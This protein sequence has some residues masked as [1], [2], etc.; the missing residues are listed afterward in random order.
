MRRASKGFSSSE[1]T[2]TLVT[3]GSSHN[4]QH[5][6]SRITSIRVVDG[7]SNS[8]RQCGQNRAC[9]DPL[10]LRVLPSVPQPSELEQL[11]FVH[12]KAVRLLGCSCSLPFVKAIGGNQTPSEFQRITERRF[13]CGCL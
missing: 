12:F 1:I 10:P 2:S 8:I 4:S 6:R 3:P 11:A 7:R 5:S 13:C 9:L